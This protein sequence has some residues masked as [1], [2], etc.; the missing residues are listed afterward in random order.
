MPAAGS[1]TITFTGNVGSMKVL[2]KG[3]EFQASEVI[4]GHLVQRRLLMNKNGKLLEDRMFPG[5][6]LANKDAK[7]APRPLKNAV[8]SSCKYRTKIINIQI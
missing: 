5:R 2:K 3:L 8:N 6:K 4:Y 7:L 1:V